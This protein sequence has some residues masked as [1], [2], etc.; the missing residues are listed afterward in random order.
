MSR[1]YTPGPDGMPLNDRRC[2]AARSDGTQ[3]TRRKKIGVFC[4]QHAPTTR[5]QQARHRQQRD[6]AEWHCRYAAY[7]TMLALQQKYES[8]GIEA[9]PRYLRPMLVEWM[10][11]TRR[12]ERST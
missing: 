2:E 8:D 5:A 3:C 6:T 4:H 1:R 7:R 9:I 10:S 12:K 11:W